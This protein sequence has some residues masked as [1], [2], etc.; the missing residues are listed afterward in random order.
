M[1]LITII[2]SSLFTLIT[3]VGVVAD[4]VAEGLIREQIYRADR[5]AVRIDNVPNFQL[6]GGR[7]DRIRVAGRGIYPVPELRIDTLDVETDPIDVDLDTLQSGRVGFD[8]PIQTAA[9]LILKTEDLNQLLRS[10]RVQDRLDQLRFN[11]P[12]GTEREAN[13]YGL[14]N[15]QIEFMPG[16]RLRITA[17]LQDRV[18]HEAVQAVVECG[19]TIE[20]GHRLVLIQP[21]I[22]V[23]GQPVPQQLLDSF[24][25][26]ISP[27]L[28]LKRLEQQHVTARVLRFHL[29]PE[30]LELA[31]FVRVEPDS[32]LLGN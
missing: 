7:V 12:G 29:T 27:D 18:L 19:F 13:R 3:P 4:Q 31:L 8:E 26:G 9:H 2:L 16:N 6:V 11:L 22:V 30:A 24:V 23:D 25:E 20:G 15:P 14:A 21:S 32:P 5:L 17:D 1:E 10:Q 28:T